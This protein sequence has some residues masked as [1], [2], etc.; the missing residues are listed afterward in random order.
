MERMARAKALGSEGE[1]EE[2]VSVAEEEGVRRG[3]ERDSN[4]GR[5]LT[6]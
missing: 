1:M 2:L 5:G 3:G 6:L 4:K